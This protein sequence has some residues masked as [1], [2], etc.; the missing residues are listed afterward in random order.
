MFG[1]NFIRIYMYVFIFICRRMHNFEVQ[2]CDTVDKIL[3][4]L[5]YQPSMPRNA[6]ADLID[7][8]RPDAHSNQRKGPRLVK[9][10]TDLARLLEKM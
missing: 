5:G 6:P 9:S 7:L 2:L 1:V 3:L 8:H 4:L 10:P